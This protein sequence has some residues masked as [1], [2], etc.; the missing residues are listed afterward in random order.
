MFTS[1]FYPA[2]EQT[3]KSKERESAVVG[4]DVRFVFFDLCVLVWGRI[5]LKC[6]GGVRMWSVLCLCFF[7]IFCL[8]EG[9]IEGEVEKRQQN[10]RNII[11]NLV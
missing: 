3:P 5:Q 9:G 8:G 7:L 10:Q 2:L 11:Q 6:K 4:S 1:P